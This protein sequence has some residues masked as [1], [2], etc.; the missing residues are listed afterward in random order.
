MSS[1]IEK[2]AEEIRESG[3]HLIEAIKAFGQKV[4]EVAKASAAMSAVNTAQ[5]KE[6]EAEK[7]QPSATPPFPTFTQ[8]LRQIEEEVSQ[9]VEKS[10]VRLRE[11]GQK[12]LRDYLDDLG[13]KRGPDPLAGFVADIGSPQSES[14]S[15]PKK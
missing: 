13:K 8:L 15:K 9:A 7:A 14:P 5:V 2:L 12:A 10:A 3:H 6:P 4:D 1:D 11:K